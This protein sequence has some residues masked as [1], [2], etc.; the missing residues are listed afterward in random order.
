MPTSRAA[1]WESTLSPGLEPFHPLT[2]AVSA[3]FFSSFLGKE[4]VR[5]AR[6]LRLQPMATKLSL[7]QSASQAAILS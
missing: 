4:E 3:F 7:L 6:P 5:R 2:R 1:R